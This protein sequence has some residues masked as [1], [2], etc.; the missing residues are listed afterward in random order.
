MRKTVLFLIAGAACCICTLL[1]CRYYYNGILSK[2]ENANILVISKQDMQ[3]HLIDY[4]GNELFSAPVAV[5]LNYGNKQK[6]GDMRTPEG[7]FQV[8]DIQDASS[9]SHDFNDGKGKIDHAYGD[10]F[11][12]LAVPGH[13]GI[14]IHGTHLP[15]SIGTR[16]SEGCIRLSNTDLERLVSL[17]YPPLT[18][19]ITPSAEDVAANIK[20]KGRK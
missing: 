2:I 14:G 4:K 5:G 16:A 9:W 3:V 13:K 17:I 7:V 20:E 6:Q 11:I 12:R 18:V 19:I 15:E 10:Y 8:A 1:G